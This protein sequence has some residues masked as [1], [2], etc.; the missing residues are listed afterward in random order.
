ME[1]ERPSGFVY[2]D[3]NFTVKGV[4]SPVAEFPDRKGEVPIER[5]ID[6]TVNPDKKIRFG[7]DRTESIREDWAENELDLKREYGSFEALEEAEWDL[8][9]DMWY[10]EYAEGAP[11]EVEDGSDVITRHGGR[12]GPP[13]KKIEEGSDEWNQIIALYNDGISGQKIFDQKLVG[14]VRRREINSVIRQYK[15]IQKSKGKHV[16]RPNEKY[17]PKEMAKHYGISEEEWNTLSKGEITVKRHSYAAYIRGKT[18]GWQQ[19]RDIKE[20]LDPGATPEQLKAIDNVFKARNI[21]KKHLGIGEL[22]IDVDHSKQK[23]RQSIGEYLHNANNLQLLTR[24]AHEIKNKLDR[25][26]RKKGA[27]EEEIRASEDAFYASNPFGRAGGKGTKP[28]W[29][30]IIDRNEDGTLQEYL[31]EIDI[32]RWVGNR[33]AISEAVSTESETTNAYRDTEAKVIDQKETVG[34]RKYVFSGKEHLPGIDYERIINKLNLSGRDTADVNVE[35]AYVPNRDAKFTTLIADKFI[36]AVKGKFGMAKERLLHGNYRIVIN[37]ARFDEAGVTEVI[38]EQANRLG[39]SPE[40]LMEKIG[41]ENLQEYAIRSVLQHEITHVN[42][43]AWE[44]AILDRTGTNFDEHELGKFRRELYK[45]YRKEI[46]SFLRKDK[47]GFARLGISTIAI[48]GNPAIEN[49]EDA[50]ELLDTLFRDAAKPASTSSQRHESSKAMWRIL[51]ELL[52]Y[53]S[54]SMN[55]ETWVTKLKRVVKMILAKVGVNIGK[56]DLNDLVDDLYSTGAIRENLTATKI[57]RGEEAILSEEEKASARARDIKA[58]ME[59]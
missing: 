40:E 29:D 8:N 20:F 41:K 42:H 22:R 36:A 30:E 13:R 28:W 19:S 56:N 46:I 37:L 21:L 2:D 44:R 48:E 32:E 43:F 52:A 11:L 12:W 15:E 4:G 24:E 3:E 10:D 18:Y 57:L 9:A 6:R 45:T 59:A 25:A 54:D 1:A 53:Q 26:A 33:D 38:S 34:E 17:T 5:A 7:K 31:N 51:S 39:I 16:R 58:K 14:D 47:N 23:S 49:N 55:T 35:F 50:I 27:T